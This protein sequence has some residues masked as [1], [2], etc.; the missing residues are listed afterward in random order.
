MRILKIILV[1]AL[2]IYATSVIGWQ[3]MLRN[4][5]LSFMPPE[6]NVSKI[7]YVEEKSWGFGPGG[8]ET[9]FIMYELPS[10]IAQK[11]S[12]EGIEYLSS[13]AS[14]HWGKPHSTHG[15]YSEWHVT[16]IK[17][18]HR[19]P[20]NNRNG[21]PEC[22]FCIDVKPEFYRAFERAIN[23]Q[24]SFYAYGRTGMILVVPSEQKVF[25]VYAG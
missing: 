8:N 12:A 22:G 14:A 19:I 15:K 18:E 16:P 23:S 4:H 17:Q 6:M 9:G 25:F 7:I 1:I 10:D 2:V 3:R 13:F 11:V 20:L 21:D 5:H 24:E